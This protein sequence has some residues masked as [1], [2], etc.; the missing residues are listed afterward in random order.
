MDFFDEVPYEYYIMT[1]LANMLWFCEDE[2]E[3]L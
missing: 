2:I 1:Q 3:V